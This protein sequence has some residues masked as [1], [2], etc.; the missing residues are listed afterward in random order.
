MLIPN[1]TCFTVIL[2][3]S[4]S[5]KETLIKGNNNLRLL[6]QKKGNQEEPQVLC[7]S[8]GEPQDEGQAGS[9]GAACSIDEIPLWLPNWLRQ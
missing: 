7:A 5:V 8:G 9:P 2:W 6:R 4:N 1:F 3:I